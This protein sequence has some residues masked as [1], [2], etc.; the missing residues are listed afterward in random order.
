[1]IF[2]KP[3]ILLFASLILLTGCPTNKKPPTMN[4]TPFITPPPEDSVVITEYVSKH[5][6]WAPTEYRIQEID[7][8]ND[9]IV[10]EILLLKEEPG[11]YD[12][13]K[14]LRVGGGESFAVYYDPVHHQ[15]VKE[16]HFQ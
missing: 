9:Y 3:S 4:S 13:S 12:P 5:K 11:P 8:E 15:V 16:A 7:R 1:M 2:M 14:P 6:S 10:Y